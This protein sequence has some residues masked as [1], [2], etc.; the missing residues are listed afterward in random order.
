MSV[1]FNSL[2]A[3]LT[4]PNLLVRVMTFV[5]FAVF[6]FTFFYNVGT[7]IGI[8]VYDIDRYIDRRKILKLALEDSKKE[9]ET[10]IQTLEHKYFFNAGYKSGRYWGMIEYQ[11]ALLADTR[12]REQEKLKEIDAIKKVKPIKSDKDWN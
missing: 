10:Y 12:M 9:L 4:N 6:L 1:I 2:I 3:Y 5:L 11:D 7:V 8:L